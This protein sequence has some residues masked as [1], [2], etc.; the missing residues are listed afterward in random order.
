MV[1]VRYSVVEKDAGRIKKSTLPYLAVEERQKALV[2]SKDALVARD[3]DQGVDG[4]CV[5]LQRTVM[6]STGRRILYD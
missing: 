5:H 3:V 1:H 4:P 2:Q 6:I